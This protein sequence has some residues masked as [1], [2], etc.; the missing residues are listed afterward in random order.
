MPNTF[1]DKVGTTT[2]QLRRGVDYLLHILPTLHPLALTVLI[3]AA[4]VVPSRLV[5][6]P[7]ARYLAVLAA[8]FVAYVALVGGD[9]IGPRFLMHI[10][11]VF[12]V[13]AVAGITALV[14][15]R[16]PMDTVG[17]H[18]PSIARESRHFSLPR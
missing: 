4:I 16:L 10:F 2:A 18:S 12:V 7:A 13:L 9:F 8:A 14:D 1:Y 11:P 3:V 17:E 6:R 15:L 5:V